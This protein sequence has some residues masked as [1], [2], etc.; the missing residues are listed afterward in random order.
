V[1]KPE[2]D[3]RHALAPGPH[4]RE[5]LF[6]NVLLP[7]EG[8]MVFFYTWVD[9][10]S[11]AGH[12]FTVVG[13]DN[14]RLAFS[15]TDGVPVGDRNF[16]DWEVQG[17]RVRHRDALQVAEL[18]YDGDGV[19]CQVTFRGLH[20]AFSYLEN[21]DGCP[22]FLA[23]DRFEQSGRLTGTLTLDGREIAIDTTGHRDHSWG[24]R[25]W[26]S[27]QDWKWISAQSGGERSLNVLL[28]HARG[29]TTRHG[30]VWRDGAVWPVLDVRYSAEYDVNWW[31]TSGRFQIRDA[32]GHETVVTAERFAFL[33]FDA[34]ENILLNEAGCR[35]TIDGEEAIVH[36]EA[37]WD[38]TYAAAQARRVAVAAAG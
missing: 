24:T 16:D 36:F 14:E 15:A 35:G 3:L 5:S 38:R 11:R 2:D 20:D 26:D 29:Q 25:D 21:D 4:A 7:D 18:A 17:L 13:D 27:I 34:G 12:L 1:P 28:M 23:D 32:G 19:S 33:T 31:Q 10:E 6:Y 37:G 30:Y 22:S 9:A 8:L